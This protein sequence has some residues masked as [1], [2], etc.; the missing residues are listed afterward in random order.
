M[1]GIT[2]A[3]APVSAMSVNGNLSDWGITV[4]DYTGPTGPTGSCGNVPTNCVGT[5]WTTLPGNGSTLAGG[6]K[7]LGS[8]LDNNP[9]EDGN[10][11]SNNYGDNP[12]VRR[13]SA[14]RISTPSSWPWHSRTASSTSRS[15]AASGRTTGTDI[16]NPAI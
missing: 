16:S 14:A 3:L 7:P 8:S 11:V 2:L 13:I 4:S 5:T 10:D 12:Q 9:V 1:L 6:A 15:S